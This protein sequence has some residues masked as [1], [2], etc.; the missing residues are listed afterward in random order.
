MSIKTD[1]DKMQSWGLGDVLYMALENEK[2]KQEHE[3]EMEKLQ[4]I[5]QINQTQQQQSQQ[6]NG[7]IFDNQIVKYGAVAAAGLVV[8][9]LVT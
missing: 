8:Y 2:E 6:S 9:K 3:R 1:T 4:Q 5:N 7:S